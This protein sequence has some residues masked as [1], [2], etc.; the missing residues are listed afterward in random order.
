MDDILPIIFEKTITEKDSLQFLQELE[1]RINYDND[2]NGE[3]A[4]SELELFCFKKGFKIA[5]KLLK[6][7][8]V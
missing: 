4:L 5:L 2:S 1:L 8:E 7:W 6:E 3:D